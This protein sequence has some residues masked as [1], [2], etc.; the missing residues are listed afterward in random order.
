[1]KRPCNG[2]KLGEE[3]QTM[4]IS[5]YTEYMPAHF[6]SR[7]N[8][9]I[10]AYWFA[11]TTDV[12]KA[13]GAYAMGNTRDESVRFLIDELATYGITIHGVKLL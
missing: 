13:S 9:M 12:D 3:E 10:P 1:M 8:A 4:R 6:N 2:P 7:A 11:T 5:V